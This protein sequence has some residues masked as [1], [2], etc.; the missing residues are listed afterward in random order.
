MYYETSSASEYRRRANAVCSRQ[1]GKLA[2][3][4]LV[5]FVILVVVG[6]IDNETAYT[7][8]LADGTVETTA[9]F[10]S[11]FT[12]LT[13]GAF[14]LSFAQ[15]HKKASQNEMVQVED[16]LVGFNDW[17]RSVTLN[18]LISLYTTLWTLLFIIPGIVKSFSYSM[19]YYIANDNP[20]LSANECIDR[21]KKMMDG[22]KFDYFCLMLSYFG[23]IILSCFTLGIAL[24]WVLPKM[25][26]A[27]Y[28]FYLDIS[29]NNYNY[30]LYEKEEESYYSDYKAQSYVDEYEVDDEEEYATKNPW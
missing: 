10:N 16:L 13:A 22:H 20:N 26:Q 23:L 15:I 27:S 12:F 28:Q 11:V 19:S 1:S 30:D 18:V 21:S 9:W 4:Y 24:L 2:I 6:F 5:Y 14:S 7:E 8:V 25:Q 29:G 17:R 3:V